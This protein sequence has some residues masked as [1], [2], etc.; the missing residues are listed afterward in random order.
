MKFIKKFKSK[1][2]KNKPLVISYKILKWLFSIVVGIMLVLIL[3]QKFSNNNLAIGG[4]RIFWVAS[5]SMKPEYDIGDIIVTK[6]VD[7]SDLK[8]GD[9]VTYHGEK[10]QVQD[11]I[12]THK[13]I[14]SRQSDGKY[15]F[16]T[17]GT[18]NE[19][20]DPEIKYSQIYGKV[21]YKTVVLSYIS[22]LMNNVY[23]YYG[24]FT[25]I[26]VMASYQIV[27]IVFDK[28]EDDEDGEE[29]IDS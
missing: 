18:A 12:V 7:A 24:M 2:E 5:E 15:Y 3:V 29:E 14:S 21:E 20:P 6:K 17:K 13:I 9:N 23:I 25:V 4:I 28:D 27:K 10:G 8:V 19:T 26:G 11:V 22:K 16:I 1:L